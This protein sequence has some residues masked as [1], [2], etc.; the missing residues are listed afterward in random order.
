MDVRVSLLSS[1]EKARLRRL[2]QSAKRTRQPCFQ[3]LRL[4]AYFLPQKRIEL[5]PVLFR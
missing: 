3:R 4:T 2:P 1:E 5:P